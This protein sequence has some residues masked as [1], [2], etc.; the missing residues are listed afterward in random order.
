MIGMKTLTHGAIPAAL[1]KAERYRL[2]NE[3]EEAESICRDVLAVEPANEAAL[4]MF[5]LAVTDLFPR[6]TLRD[7]QE[8]QARLASA[9]DRAYYGGIILER[10]AKAQLDHVPPNVTY[11]LISDAL[12]AYAEAQKLGGDD[13]PDAILRWNACVRLLEARPDLQPKASD[14]PGGEG[15]GWDE[16]PT[17]PMTRR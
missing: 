11:H 7:A 5:L 16:P 10:W 6:R 17:A 13:N 14:E 9:Y 8:V 4:V 15:Y 3:P 12:A 2:L 1:A